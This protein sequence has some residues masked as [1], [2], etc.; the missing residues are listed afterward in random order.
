MKWLKLIENKLLASQ[1]GNLILTFVHVFA[2]NLQV[3]LEKQDQLLGDTQQVLVAAQTE[4]QNLKIKLDTAT[5][6]KVRLFF[7]FCIKNRTGLIL[8]MIFPVK[9]VHQNQQ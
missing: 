6:E 1:A 7:F 4:V 3:K 9:R 8:N 5:R 2:V